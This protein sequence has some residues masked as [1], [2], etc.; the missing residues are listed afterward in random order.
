[1]AVDGDPDSFVWDNH[2]AHGNDSAGG[3]NWL[4]VDLG[5]QYT[6]SNVVLTNRRACCSE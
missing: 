5:E 6:I 3:P 4:A 2:C 1:M